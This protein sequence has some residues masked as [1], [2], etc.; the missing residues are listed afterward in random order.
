MRNKHINCFEASL[1]LAYSIYTREK[2]AMV[3]SFTGTRDQLEPLHHM[4]PKED[5]EMAKEAMNLQSVC[6]RHLQ[7]ALLFYDF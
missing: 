2:D 5:F 3:Y 4:L 7:K 6:Y 1:L